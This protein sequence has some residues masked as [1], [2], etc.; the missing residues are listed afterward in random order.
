[1]LKVIFLDLMNTINFELHKG[2]LLVHITH[3]VY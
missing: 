1:M 2:D 3:F